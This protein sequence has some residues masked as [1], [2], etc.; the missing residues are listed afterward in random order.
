VWDDSSR[1]FQAAAGGTDVVLQ[2]WPELAEPVVVP[3]NPAFDML[4]VT[5][6]FSDLNV[7]GFS[8]AQAANSAGQ[9]GPA[10]VTLTLPDLGPADGHPHRIATFGFAP[11]GDMWIGYADADPANDFGGQ[12]VAKV[13]ASKLLTS[14]AVTPDFAF[15]IAAAGMSTLG[16][17]TILF[18]PLGNMWVSTIASTG[19]PSGLLLYPAASIASAGSP[20][21]TVVIHQSGISHAWN[22]MIFDALGNMWYTDA[23]AGTVN[24]L[25]ASQLLSSNAAIVPAIVLSIGPYTGLALDPNNNL[26]CSYAGYADLFAASDILS[27]SAPSSLRRILKDATVGTD[28]LGRNTAIGTKIRF[29]KAGNFW[30][31]TSHGPNGFTASDI[32]VSG[33]PVPRCTLRDSGLLTNAKQMYFNPASFR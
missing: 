20:L 21:P 32:A 25:S 18:D 30:A 29:D 31:Q 23:L 4:W 5:Q 27:T 13:S 15:P 8:A 3:F 11:N 26:W 6:T 1:S 12:Y 19:Q 22:D 2:S 33:T 28:G 10:A 16:V 9:L 17:S 7:F 14:G 24:R